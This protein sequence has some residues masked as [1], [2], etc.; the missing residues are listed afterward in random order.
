MCMW[1]LDSYHALKKHGCFPGQGT[2]TFLQLGEVGREQ[3]A[4]INGITMGVGRLSS[5]RSGLASE[6]S[7]LVMEVCHSKW[8]SY[9]PSCQQL[10]AAWLPEN[11]CFFS[12]TQTEWVFRGG[13]GFSEKEAW[14][15]LEDQKREWRQIWI[16]LSQVS[17]KPSWWGVSSQYQLLCI[18][19]WVHKYAVD[20]SASF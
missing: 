7:I 10:S 17:C 20:A 12:F 14:S 13:R 4:P 6:E 3:V 18:W 2:S 8:Q 15:I 5:L 16:N 1:S 11:T 19:M 9:S